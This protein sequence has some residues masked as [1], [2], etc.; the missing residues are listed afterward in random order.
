MKFNSIN[1]DKN[2]TYFENNSSILVAGLKIAT[3]TAAVAGTFYA[4]TSGRINLHSEVSVADEKTIDVIDFL[5]VFSLECS[6]IYL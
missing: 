6:L 5:P 1:S 2:T 3:L 4:F